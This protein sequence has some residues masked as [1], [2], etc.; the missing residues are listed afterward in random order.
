RAADLPARARPG[1]DHELGAAAPQPPDRLRGGGRARR[2]AA[3][4]RPG[5]DGVRD[6]ATDGALRGVDLARRRLRAPLVAGHEP[7]TQAREHVDARQ[8]G[9]LAVRLQE[10]RGLPRLDRATAERGEQLDQAEVA[11]EPALV[12]AEALQADHA[13][14]PRA[15]SALALEAR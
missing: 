1:R 10:L 15:E 7:A 13:D 12:P 8:P 2:G 14:R 5:D 4:R 3:G 9:P 6:G 11:L